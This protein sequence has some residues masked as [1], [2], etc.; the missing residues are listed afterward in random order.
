MDM[1]S[2]SRGITITSVFL[3]LIT[4]ALKPYNQIAM[5]FLFFFFLISIYIAIKSKEKGKD[6]FGVSAMWGPC[7]AGGMMIFGRILTSNVP[8]V[9]GG[10]TGACIA[11]LYI[12]TRRHL[13]NMGRKKWTKAL[14]LFVCCFMFV[15]SYIIAINSIFDNSPGSIH[16]GTITNKAYLSK[17]SIPVIY[18]CSEEFPQEDIGFIVRGSVW[19]ASSIG[20]SIIFQRYSG[21]FGWP[22]Y[23]YVK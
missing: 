22:W 12:F 1:S 15:A 7:I 10:I 3:A 9:V 6:Y 17:N 8:F 4:F 21:L 5:V 23:T 2:W 20:D 13:K 11:I 19:R 14:A 16:Q 18:L